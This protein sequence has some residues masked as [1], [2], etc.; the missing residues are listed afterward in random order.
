MLYKK[1]K[2]VIYSFSFLTIA[3]VLELLYLNTTQNISND[4]IKLKKEFVSLIQLPDLAISTEA[5][6]IRH[7]SLS[8]TFDIYKDDG[9]LR[10][11]FPSSFVIMNSKIGSK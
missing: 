11:Y 2:I 4:Q 8:T 10:E 3:L 1:A 9:V 5:T 7:R 6:F